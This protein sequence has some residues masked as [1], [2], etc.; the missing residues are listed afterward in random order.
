M[1]ITLRRPLSG[2]RQQM[3]RTRGVHHHGE[4]MW[5]RALTDRREP[6]AGPSGQTYFRSSIRSDTVGEIAGQAARAAKR[7]TRVGASGRLVNQAA[8]R[9]RLSAAAAATFCRPVLASPR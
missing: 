2:I 9:S 7:D 4:E 1:R 3:G 6:R 8:R 5:R